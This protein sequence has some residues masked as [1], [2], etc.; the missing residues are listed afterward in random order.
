MRPDQPTPS[1][2]DTLI[3]EMCRAGGMREP[4]RTEILS[5]EGPVIFFWEAEDFSAAFELGAF[6]RGGQFGWQGRGDCGSAAPRPGP[7]PGPSTLPDDL[8]DPAAVEDALKKLC[9]RG[10]LRRPDR[11]E[12]QDDGDLIALWDEEKLAV[13]I[14]MTG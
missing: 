2:V 7:A 12:Q 13:V 11:I 5:A 9:D 3:R 10:D 4:D 1:E 6:V 8:P 14:E